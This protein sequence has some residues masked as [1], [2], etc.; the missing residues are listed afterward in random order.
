[1]RF[2]GMN[3]N[4]VNITEVVQRLYPTSIAVKFIVRAD[5]RKEATQIAEVIIPRWKDRALPEGP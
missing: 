3:R 1:V 5:S 4:E 2:T